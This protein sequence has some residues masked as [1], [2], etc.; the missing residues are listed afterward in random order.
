MPATRI[1]Q[2]PVLGIA[3]AE[4]G[5][6]VSD[7]NYTPE[8]EKGEQINHLGDYIGVYFYR[9]RVT[10][11]MTGEIPFKQDSEAN[12]EFGMGT[13][14][15]L[16]NECPPTIWLGGTAPEGTTAVIDNAPYQRQRDAVATVTVSGTIYPFAVSV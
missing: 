14:L 5:V 2:T 8:C 16:Q 12:P 15:A 1:G 13:S 9:Q 6:F 3:K 4:N 10:F 7:I 11:S